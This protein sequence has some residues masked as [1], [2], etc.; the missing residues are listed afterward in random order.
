MWDIAAKCGWKPDCSTSHLLPRVS[1]PCCSIHLVALE[2]CLEQ[3]E[4]LACKK[5]HSRPSLSTLFTRSLLS[6]C[7]LLALTKRH[8]FCR[9]YHNVGC[10]N[11]LIVNA[12]QLFAH[13]KS[14]GR[15]ALNSFGPVPRP[16]YQS[17]SLESI[18]SI[19]RCQQSWVSPMSFTPPVDG[20]TSSDEQQ[21]AP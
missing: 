11:S 8:C 4:L 12:S 19:T 15:C 18:P 14:I 17:Q 2:R 5:V 10:S 16:W 21:E 1:S 7:L 3:Q 6:V 13:I 20:M 9:T